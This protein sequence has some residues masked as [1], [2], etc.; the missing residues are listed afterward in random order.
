MAAAKSNTNWFAIGV[1]IA[2]VVVLVAIGGLVV[3]LNNQATSPGATPK[4]NDTFNS[5]TGAI[6]FG[7]GEDTV[8]VFVDFQCPICNSFEQQFGA[9]LEAAAAD[10]RIT[11]E[12]HPIAILDRYSQG[13][14]YS[15][16]SAGAA[17]CVAESN[18][19]L[20]LDYAKVLFENQ[21]EENSSG[22][23]T[24]QLAD[25]ATQVGADDAVSCIT[26]ETYRK[27]GVAQAKQHEIGGT[28]TIDINGERLNLQ[29]QADMKKFTDLIS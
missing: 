18:P 28:P 25:F 24:D 10:G 7:D 6:T 19:D 29:D 12:Y 1:S 16:R 15:S 11:L 3:F 5:E 26:D 4:A 17:V 14:E 2:V 9:Q 21:P 13:T 22:L 23:T 27:F 20:Y 8:A